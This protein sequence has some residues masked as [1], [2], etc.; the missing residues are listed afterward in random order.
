MKPPKRKKLWTE[1][2]IYVLIALGVY[3]AVLN[4]SPYEKVIGLM[5]QSIRDSLIA[6]FLTT[7]PLLGWV[8]AG[9]G[10]TAIWAV[11]AMA[12]FIIQVIEVLPL[13]VFSDDRLLLTIIQ[14]GDR[15]G[16]QINDSDDPMLKGIK[17][18]YNRIPLMIVRNLKFAQIFTYTLD[19]ILIMLVYPPINGNASDFMFVLAVG[20][21]GAIN[22]LNI[23]MG[24]T[25]LFAVEIIVIL[26]IYASRLNEMYKLSRGV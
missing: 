5:T 22:W 11:A 9:F 3:F 7:I 2:G 26:L 18:I 12:W 10:K 19:F 23:F 8:V 21:L 6:Q 17:R 13:V 15:K 16:Y 1:Y 24:F 4:I 14:E 20:D 25:T